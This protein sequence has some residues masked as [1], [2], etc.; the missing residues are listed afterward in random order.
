MAPVVTLKNYEY[1]FGD[2]GYIVNSDFNNTLPFYDVDTITGLDGAP[3]RVNSASRNDRDGAWVS[4]TYVDMRTIAINGT[5]YTNSNDPDTVLDRLRAE[6]A[7]K[8]IGYSTPYGLPQYSP[9]AV[10]PF[11]FQHPGKP[12][13]FVLAQGGGAQYSIDSSR[14]TGL[15]P[16]QLTLL[17]GDP[18]IYDFPPTDFTVGG[19]TAG[20][21]NINP[22]FETG[23]SPWT[24]I[25]NATIIQSSAVVFSGYYTLRINGNGATANPIARSEVTI[26]VTVG[27]KYQGT[28]R[29]YSPSAWATGVQINIRWYNSGGSFLSA[30]TGTSAALS[31]TT[32]TLF[33]VLG[34]APASAAFASIDA[35]I[36]GTPTSG[37]FFY[38]D[39]ALLLPAGGAS[40]PFSFAS[41]F[42]GNVKFDPNVTVFNNGTH[43]SYPLFT[44][45]G[46]IR[47]P[48]ITD[49]LTWDQMVFNIT[50]SNLDIL[51]VDP[52]NKAVILQAGAPI[53]WPPKQGP[54][55]DILIGTNFMD[56]TGIQPR[57]RTKYTIRNARATLQGLRFFT[58]PSKA[59]VTF[60]L[61]GRNTT[62]ATRFRVT[63]YNTYD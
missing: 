2:N 36:L 24:A 42:G 7:P 56:P 8:R 4:A 60:Y 55:S 51:V 32:W 6:Y 45:Y 47:D 37:Q 1:A 43:T 35:S 19:N 12:L 31:A 61:T 14:R 53:P 34:T 13:R 44:I 58:V 29:F 30:T 21:L 39:E 15:T 27:S 10:Q 40:F 16:L 25:N 20:P 52:R 59:A 33:S 63:N 11:W 18:Y 3:P 54:V 17:A 23:V 5:M 48:V 57:P 9:T 62:S 49:S 38:T 50:L 22:Y 28:I 46:P 26:P 41:N